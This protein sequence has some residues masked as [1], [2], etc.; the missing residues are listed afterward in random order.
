V[1]KGYVTTAE[2]GRLIY[3]TDRRVRQLY[4]AGVLKGQLVGRTL[5]IQLSSIERY[6]RRKEAA[7]R[8]A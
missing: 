7:K 3:K 6:Q 5:L 2:A 4:R 8:A 1:I